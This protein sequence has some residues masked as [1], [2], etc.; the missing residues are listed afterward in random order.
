MCLVLKLDNG[1]EVSIAIG[2]TESCH[3]PVPYYN[4]DIYTTKMSTANK[5]SCGFD[6]RLQRKK[7]CTKNDKEIK[8]DAR[9]KQSLHSSAHS[10]TPY[11]DKDNS[12]T[13]LVLPC[14][15]L[16]IYADCNR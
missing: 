10:H 3:H 15:N 11:F 16:S 8:N 2:Q 12:H 9:S 4:I 5:K 6:V 13:I 1:K 7:F 14:L